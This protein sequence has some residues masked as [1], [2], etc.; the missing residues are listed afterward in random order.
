MKELRKQITLGVLV[1]V[2]MSLFIAL[3]AEVNAS[4]GT[5]IAVKVLNALA[6]VLV[7]FV[8][9]ILAANGMLPEME[10]E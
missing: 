1:L 9:R 7:G 3:C 10:D 8:G 5:I 2:G 4:V 6:L